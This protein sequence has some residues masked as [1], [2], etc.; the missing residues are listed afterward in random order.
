VPRKATSNL[1]DLFAASPVV[2]C[3]VVA[4]LASALEVWAW[5]EVAYFHL[6]FALVTAR[7]GS[8]DY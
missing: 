5:V 1:G 7:P 6:V 2:K 3:S 8:S 4:A